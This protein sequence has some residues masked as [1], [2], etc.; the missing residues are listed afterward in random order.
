MRNVAVI[1]IA[2][3]AT[4]VRSYFIIL[5]SVRK[6]CGEGD[7]ERGFRSGSDPPSALAITMI[8]PRME[9]P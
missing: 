3:S 8:S 9:C 6:T 7:P 5:L 2:Q 1:A 4:M